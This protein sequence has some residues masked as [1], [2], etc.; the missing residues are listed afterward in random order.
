LLRARKFAENAY[1]NEL[2]RELRGFGYRI[3]N[4]TRG[5]FQIEASQMNCVTV[6]RS[7]TRRLMR[8][9]RSCWPTSPS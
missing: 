8:L 6:S 1:Y 9:W 2:A 3:R 5:D 7:V 4:R